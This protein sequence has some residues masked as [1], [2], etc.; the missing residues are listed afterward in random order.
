MRSGE[1]LHVEMLN[2]I[3][4][5]A[6]RVFRDEEIARAWLLTPIISL[7][8]RRP[9]DHLDSITGYERVKDAL[10]KIEYGQY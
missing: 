6:E 5:E 8:N 1:N 3:L 2:E 7:D 9:L 4:Q 10:G